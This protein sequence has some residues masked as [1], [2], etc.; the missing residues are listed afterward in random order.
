MKQ[1]KHNGWTNYATWR[2]NLE[3]I[4][5]INFVRD[6]VWGKSVADF[7]EQLQ[8]DVETRL[9]EEFDNDTRNDS[10][11][12]SYA[13]A[14]IQDVNWYEIAKDVNESYELGLTD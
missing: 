5:G 2:V 7:A 6:D 14:F 8:G 11:A 9:D 4:D 3:Q 10:Y 1:E 12:N 13:H